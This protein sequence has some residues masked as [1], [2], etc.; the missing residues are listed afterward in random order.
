[1]SKK[2]IIFGVAFLFTTVITGFT[3]Y[4]CIILYGNYTIDNKQFVMNETTTVE[5]FQGEV[6]SHLYLENRYLVSIDEI[7]DHVKH[8]FIAVEDHRF[9][10]H[11]GIDFKSIG[12]AL[13]RDI[14]TR[15][16][17]EG[18]STIT[19]QLAKNVFLSSEKTVLRKTKEVLIAVNLESRYSKD[20]IL[21]MYLNRIYFGHGAYGIQAASQL[22]FNKDVSDLT[23]DE[24]ALLAALPKAPNHFSPLKDLERGKDRRNVVLGLMERHGYLSAEEAVRLQGRNIPVNHVAQTNNA[25]YHSYIDLVLE[26]AE[27]KY[28]L[29][30][31]EILRG[32]Y[33][34]V[35]EMD[36][37]LQQTTYDLFQD[38]NNFP[39]ST[40]ENIV[41]GSIVLISNETGGVAAVQGGRE[42]VR[43]GF[44]RAHAKRQPGSIFKP[45]AV[46]AP[47]LE[48]GTFHPY[49]I[50]PDEEIDYGGYIPRNFSN[51]YEGEITIYDAMKDSANA[52]AVWLLNE[53]G[54]DVA[55]NSLEKQNI[56]LDD[57]GLAIALGGIRD[58]VSPLQIAAAYS[59]YAN[60]GNY[61]EP[62]YIRAIYDRNGVLVAQ[63]E[64]IEME[65]LS[66][67][68]AWYMTR[69]L[70][71]VVS[72]GTGNTGVY[73]GPL[74][75][76]TGTTAYE[77]VAGANR[78]IWFAGYTPELS[79]AIWM[80]YDR[81]DENNFLTASS[82]VPT[83]LFKN[84]LSQSINEEE[85]EVAFH[86]PNGIE[87]LDAPIRFVG[88]HDLSAKA[89]LSWSGG[90]VNLSWSGS[91]D[92]RLQYIIYEKTDEG[93]KKI[94]EIT[95]TEYTINRVNLFSLNSYIVVP[96]NPQIE[97][98]GE[99]SNIAKAEFHLFSN[100]AS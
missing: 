62:F 17:A 46:F 80:G 99:P 9:Y 90:K 100:E 51:T 63:N 2:R 25:A 20:E 94:A 66:P 93:T 3:L 1:M 81:T 84:V 50:I 64:G 59:T 44:N 71:A 43:K 83:T 33:R 78:D 55:K 74:A 34:I 13:Y 76:K 97:R 36:R 92:E 48:T 60:S 10:S 47:A 32:G 73:D 38:P 29:S 53:L 35:V 49:S 72:D 54:T 24:G 41:E 5:D 31:E 21:E 18:A 52:P 70:E 6:I 77:N 37:N 30:E 87:D 69:M 45:L 82:S 40:G 91:D 79:G 15:S 96:Y 68:T 75:G 89:S 85:R 67:Q 88:I 14:V 12:R 98:E 4:L 7:P 23:V 16:K 56:P 61:R 22:Y 11:Q 8:A 26:E 39:A 95:D 65:V 86:I 19:Q 27:Q 57:N 42:Y 58:G 28:H